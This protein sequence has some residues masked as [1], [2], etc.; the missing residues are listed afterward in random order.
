MNK[1]MHLMKIIKE[2]IINAY[3]EA[4]FSTLSVFAIINSLILLLTCL[5]NKRDYR[6]HDK[7]IK[8]SI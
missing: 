2:I 1:Y 5:G 8:K 7:I 4:K 3:L 6:V